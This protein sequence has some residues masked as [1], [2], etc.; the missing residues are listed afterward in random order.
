MKE[1]KENARPKERRGA[2]AGPGVLLGTGAATGADGRAGGAELDRLERPKDKKETLSK[3]GPARCWVR[4]PPPRPAVTGRGGESWGRPGREGG[5]AATSYSPAARAA[6]TAVAVP[7]RAAGGDPPAAAQPDEGAAGGAPPAPA[8]ARLLRV[9]RQRLQVR[10]PVRPGRLPRGAA[11]ASRAPRGAAA[12]SSWLSRSCLP[13]ACTLTCS[14]EPTSTLK[15]RKTLSSSGIA[16]TATSLSITKAS[17]RCAALCWRVCGVC[18]LNLRGM[19]V[20]SLAGH[21]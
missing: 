19:C 18:Q 2:A 9:L 4:A 6:L 5:T 14:R 8:R 20:S 13:A 17:E 16:L 7:C 11:A 1:D 10:P 3:V 21:F 15:T 12:S